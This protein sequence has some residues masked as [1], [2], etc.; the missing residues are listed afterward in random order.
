MYVDLSILV[1]K[2]NCALLFLFHETYYIWFK[3]LNTA[4]L[5]VLGEYMNY[6][7]N[8]HKK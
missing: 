1:S 7:T 8:T 5:L 3:M 2:K 6:Y 4:K